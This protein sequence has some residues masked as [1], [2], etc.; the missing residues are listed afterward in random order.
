MLARPLVSSGAFTLARLSKRRAGI[1]PTLLTVCAGPKVRSI[2][3]SVA[4]SRRAAPSGQRRSAR[5]QMALKR[6]DVGI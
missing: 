3:A 1:T 2:Y 4:R 6:S 5:I